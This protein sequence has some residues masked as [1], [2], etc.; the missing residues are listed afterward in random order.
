MPI[1]APVNER[2]AAKVVIVDKVMD[3]ASGTFG[4]RLKLP[5]NALKLPA[6]L[7]REGSFMTAFIRPKGQHNAKELL[8][9]FSRMELAMA[10]LMAE[11]KSSQAEV[12]YRFF[13]S[14]IH[15]AMNE[16]ISLSGFRGDAG[17]LVEASLLFLH[18]TKVITLQN[19]LGVFRQA[20]T[21]ALEEEAKKRTCTKGD[22]EP[23]SQHYD[24]KNVQ[25]HV[26]EKYAQIGME[27][28]ARLGMKKLKKAVDFVR[29]YFSHS[30]DQFIKTHFA[31]QKK[32]ITTAMTATAFNE[33]I[34]SL[35]KKV[36]E[37]IV[38]APE[39]HNLLV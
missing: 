6:G 35:G 39:D 36:Q 25:V 1:E 5:N 23:L 7:I 11:L 8:G 30:Q 28:F 32:I 9:L 20:F 26:M 29:D 17:R 22:Y 4:V 15:Q 19:G 10:D 31:D 13:I 21:L 18:D 14:D 16:D 3:A 27:E 24:Q 37:A 38:A 34:Q 12:L 2:F 33:I